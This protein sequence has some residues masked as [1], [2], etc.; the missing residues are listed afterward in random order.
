MATTTTRQPAPVTPTSGEA[1]TLIG[2]GIQVNGRVSGEEDLYVQGRVEGSIHLTETLFVAVQGVVV[3]TVQA[4][5]V[6]VEGVVLGN[7]K[8]E[9]SVTLKAGAKLVGDIEAPRVIIADGAAF[10]GNVAMGQEVAARPRERR[11]V[12]PQLR[13][14]PNTIEP[15][16]R[17]RTVATRLSERTPAPSVSTSSSPPT[18]DPARRVAAIPRPQLRGPDLEEQTVVVRHSELETSD[19]LEPV[20]GPTPENTARK[21]PPRARVPKPGKRRVHR[22]P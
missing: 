11:A 3:A 12:T 13:P 1:Q 6:V 18:P 8:A 21:G 4:R 10:R 17:P 19:G 2:P 20:G 14:R 22:R 5:D 9:D 7:V 16:T 15:S